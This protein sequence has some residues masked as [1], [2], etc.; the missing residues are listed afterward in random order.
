VREQHE[1]QYRSRAEPAE[2]RRALA[3]HG[4]TP[5]STELAVQ[6]LAEHTVENLLRASPRQV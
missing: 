2:N 6:P 4:A 1:K 3:N 5:N